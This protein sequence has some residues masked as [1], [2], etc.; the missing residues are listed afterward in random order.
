MVA[1]LYAYRL[2]AALL[3]ATPA[4]LLAGSIVSGYPRGDA[5]FFD[6]GGVMLMEAARLARRS[7]TPLVIQGGLG[8]LIAAFLGLLPFAALIAALGHEGKLS[9]RFLASRAVAPLGPLALLWGS[10]LLAQVVVVALVVMVGEKLLVQAGLSVLREDL[11]RLG[12]VALGALFAL[13][14]GV[15]H[16]LARVI[17]ILENRGFYVSAARALL[18]MERA[19]ARALW[20]YAW[21][22]V[23][24][25]A[26]L[27]CAGWIATTLSRSFWLIA[28]ASQI[29]V[30]L[31][32]FLRAS[33]LASAIRIA[34]SVE[35]PVVRSLAV[36]LDELSARDA[37]P[38]ADAPAPSA[39]SA[40]SASGEL[41]D[42]KPGPTPAN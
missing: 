9:A 13:A 4:A 33:W 29:S 39:P 17:A 6:P 27:S 28:L 16:D 24:A 1:L 25:I 7:L 12:I 36:E 37:P 22:G 30:F 32:V 41:T 42:D 19:S 8:A 3:I 21:R 23:L 35:V 5:E 40:S 31:A 38:P 34:S 15:L 26:A 2:I 20:A 14:I 18:V 10:A 11:A